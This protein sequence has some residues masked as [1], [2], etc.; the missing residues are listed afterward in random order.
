MTLDEL[1]RDRER[2]RLAVLELPGLTTRE[3][4]ITLGMI[5]RHTL[6]DLR[7]LERDGLVVSWWDGRACRWFPPG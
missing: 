4:A 6:T 5:D 3:L 1:T 7:R 2:V